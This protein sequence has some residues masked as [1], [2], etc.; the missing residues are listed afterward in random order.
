VFRK[1]DRAARAL[2]AFCRA[3]SRDEEGH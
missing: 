3:N 2:A 1:I